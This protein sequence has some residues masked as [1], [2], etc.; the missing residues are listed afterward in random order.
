MKTSLGMLPSGILIA[1]IL[2]LGAFWFCHGNATPPMGQARQKRVVARKAESPE[3]TSDSDSRMPTSFLRAVPSEQPT[4]PLEAG[5]G[6][7]GV[8]P[9]VRHNFGEYRLA[10]ALRDHAAEETF[11]PLLISQRQMAVECAREALQ[12]AK[13][14]E[15]RAL[16]QKCL[17]FLQIP[18]PM[19]RF[20]AARSGS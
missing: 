18:Q 9:E 14:P 11:Y 5:S 17:S 1:G 12:A 19:K 13:T 15:D 3:A 2:I 10:L 8:S 7:G 20:H 16:A 6:P 4:V